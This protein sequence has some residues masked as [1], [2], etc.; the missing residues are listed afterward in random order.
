MKRSAFE[1]Q[2][3]A[4]H[5]HEALRL[6]EINYPDCLKWMQDNWLGNKYNDEEIQEAYKNWLW[7]Q[8]NG[9]Y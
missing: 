8:H 2:Y 9:V 5:F 3:I 1:A 7:S 4:K 6:E